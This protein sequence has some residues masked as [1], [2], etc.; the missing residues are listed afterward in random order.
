MAAQ[1][2]EGLDLIEDRLFWEIHRFAEPGRRTLLARP[3]NELLAMADAKRDR[4]R[5]YVVGQYAS[6]T[7]G[8]WAMPMEGPGLLF[9]AATARAEG[10]DALVRR[11]VALVP[12]VWGAAAAGTAGGQDLFVIPEDVNGNP[13]VFSL[14]PHAAALALGDPDSSAAVDPARA[15]DRRRG[16]L[17]IVSPRTVGLAGSLAGV[18]VEGPGIALRSDAIAGAVVATAVGGPTLQEADRLLVTAV[19]RVVPTGLEYTD[20]WRREV[21]DPGRPPLRIEP[22]RSE[23]LWR[24]DG[25]V[26][27]YPLDNAGRR[28]AELEGHRTDEG[29]RF[30][31]DG[32]DGGLHW[33]LVA[34]AP[35]DPADAP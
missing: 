23:I 34:E 8:A 35:P 15:W 30:V 13:Q 28:R 10:W 26:R 1:G 22:I 3:T 9:A 32:R 11:G 29:T 21:A 2:A 12:D 27:A 20:H 16:V 24:R 14:L 7:D 6:Y 19:G 4:R 18:H 5:P 25:T 33:E 31:L 17:R